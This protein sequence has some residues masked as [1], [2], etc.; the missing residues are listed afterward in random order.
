MGVWFKDGMVDPI[1]GNSDVRDEWAS[2]LPACAKSTALNTPGV[3]LGLG[4]KM[5][6]LSR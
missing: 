6:A 1:K 2:G 5:W 4:E 3:L